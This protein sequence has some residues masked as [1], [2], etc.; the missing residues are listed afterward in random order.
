MGNEDCDGRGRVVFNVLA[1]WVENESDGFRGGIAGAG[2][3]SSVY[4]SS[5]MFDKPTM[6][7]GWSTKLFRANS[8]CARAVYGADSAT[9]RAPRCEQL[10]K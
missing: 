5:R 3:S 7:A 1:D 8:N 9:A 2:R 10:V 6:A 4:I